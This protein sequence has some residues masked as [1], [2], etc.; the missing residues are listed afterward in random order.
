VNVARGLCAT[1]GNLVTPSR[2][3]TLGSKAEV[4]Q[5]LDMIA[6]AKWLHLEAD[7]LLVECTPYCLSD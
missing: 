5:I 3:A 1:R 7:T 2:G 4:P 6:A